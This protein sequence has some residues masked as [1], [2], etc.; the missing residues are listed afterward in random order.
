MLN[1]CGFITGAG[2]SMNCAKNSVLDLLH[3]FCCLLRQCQESIPCPS[4]SQAFGA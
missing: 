1:E 4:F 3:L 2:R